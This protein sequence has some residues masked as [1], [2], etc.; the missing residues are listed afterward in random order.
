MAS[1][2]TTVKDLLQQAYLFSG[3]LGEG[4]IAEGDRAQMG[5][6]YLNQLITSANM[7]VFLPFAQVIKD[8]PEG[9]NLYIL[10]EDQSLIEAGEIP[11]EVRTW[12]EGIIIEAKKPK[13]VNSLAF[14][15]GLRYTM[16]KH[17]GTPNIV[18]YVLPIKATP[19]L[20]SYEEFPDYTAIL[21]NRPTAFPLRATYSRSIEMADMDGKLNVPMQYTEYLMFGLAYRLAVKYQQPVESIASVKTLFNESE[22]NIKEL[23]K[24]DHS[25]TWADGDCGAD[26]WFGTVFAPPQWG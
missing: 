20:Y 14:K 18:Q 15:M 19:E 16:L 3:A 6:F 24:N 25:I 5:L 22:A 13:I 26:G 8:L 1:T 10:T 11:E 12:G 9:N 21:L 2:I 4:E 23:V 7:Q 17:S